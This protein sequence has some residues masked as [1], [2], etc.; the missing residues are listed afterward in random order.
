MKNYGDYL[1]TTI[2]HEY[3]WDAL[4][5]EREAWW[6]AGNKWEQEAIVRSIRNLEYGIGQLEAQMTAWENH[7]E[8]EDAMRSIKTA[9]TTKRH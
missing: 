9:L 4:E 6:N 5:A 3:A 2:S 7:E 1:T 8:L